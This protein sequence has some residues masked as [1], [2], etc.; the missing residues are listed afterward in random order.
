MC[1]SKLILC[2]PAVCASVLRATH[3]CDSSPA[4][5]ASVLRATHLC[6]SLPFAFVALDSDDQ[7]TYDY[8]P[9]PT[10]VFP[11]GGDPSGGFP[12]GIFHKT[13]DENQDPNRVEE[14]LALEC[15]MLCATAN[16]P[17]KCQGLSGH[18]I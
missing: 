17:P 9:S 11:I 3:L 12:N 18:Y 14:A 16:V 8:N 7:A 13:P 4:V 15:E 10:G 2:S 5:C 1:T 6:D